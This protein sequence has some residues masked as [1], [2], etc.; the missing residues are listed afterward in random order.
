MHLRY[1]AIIHRHTHTDTIHMVQRE[2]ERRE[3]EKCHDVTH[4]LVDCRYLGFW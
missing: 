3:G 1:Q 4:W 2:R